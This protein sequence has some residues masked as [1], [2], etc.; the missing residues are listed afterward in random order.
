MP[1]VA[2]AAVVAFVVLFVIAL[3][4]LSIVQRYRMGTARRRARGWIA[5]VNA[6]GLAASTGILVAVAALTSTWAPDAFTYTL[7]GLAGGAL[8]GLLGLAWSRWE[9][10]PLAL[11]YTPNKW[12]V[13]GI[14]VV[15][16][17]RILYGFWRGWQ[18]WQAAAGD[19]SWLAAAGVAG[20]MAAGAVVLGYYLTYWIGIR[21]R[22]NR[23]KAGRF[24]RQT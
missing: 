10:G 19:E 17:A 9:P 15:V 13:L 21:Y 6:L 8:L 22:L 1:V 24:G 7:M 11:H 16:T 5:T 18:A 4:P 20:S 3:V 2:L 14:T 12:L 23:Y